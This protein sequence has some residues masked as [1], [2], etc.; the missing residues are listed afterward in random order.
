MYLDLLTPG[1]EPNEKEVFYICIDCGCR[2]YF[3]DFCEEC[4]SE[5]LIEEDENC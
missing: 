3:G 5:D 2:Q 4:E 1:D